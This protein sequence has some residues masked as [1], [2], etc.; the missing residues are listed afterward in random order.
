MASEPRQAKQA[1]RPMSRLRRAL[2]AALAIVV[3]LGGVLALLHRETILSLLF[4]S[5][6]VGGDPSH[7]TLHLPSGFSAS[8][9]ASG[10]ETPRFIAFGPDG[11]LFVANRGANDVVAL[12]DP[13]HTGAATRRV[14]IA[15]GLNDPTSVAFGGSDLYV[16]E[17]TRVTRFTLAPD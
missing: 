2:L 13:G 6:F 8:V 16:G 4:A 7:T 14:V 17:Q 15:S 9:F 11:A 1:K 3:V 12:L 10:L 5:H